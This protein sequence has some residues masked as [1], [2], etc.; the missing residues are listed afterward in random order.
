MGGW[1]AYSVREI[2]NLFEEYEFYATTEAAH[3]Q[4]MRRTAAAEYV[5]CIDWDDPPQRKRLL[6]LVDDVLTHY[7][8][9]EEGPDRSEGGRL[10]RACRRALEPMVGSPADAEQEVPLG[11]AYS[12]LTHGVSGSPASSNSN[13]QRL[14]RGRWRLRH[15]RRWE[16]SRI[17]S[18]PAS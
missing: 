7:P 8:V 11:D 17:L 15:S 16:R 2:G 18:G 1:G 10:R 13:R 4:G 3:E 14:P 6:E 9:P 12:R 5:D